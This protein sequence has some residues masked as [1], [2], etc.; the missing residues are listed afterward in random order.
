VWENK[1]WTQYPIL[2][3]GC[4]SSHPKNPKIGFFGWCIGGCWVVQAHNLKMGQQN[5]QNN[6]NGQQDQA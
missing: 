6:W 4:L 3:L 5:W 2:G 1:L